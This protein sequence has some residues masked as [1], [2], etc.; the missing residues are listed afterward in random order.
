MASASTT[1]PD[2]YSAAIQAHDVLQ[3][4]RCDTLDI[5]F[6]QVRNNCMLL[7]SQ[8][9]NSHSR[10]DQDCANTI[11][12]QHSSFFPIAKQLHATVASCAPTTSQ[13]NI[14]IAEL[15]GGTLS[16]TPTNIQS[17]NA[18]CEGVDRF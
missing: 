8:M 13:L 1:C 7:F 17:C 3:R 12:F 6:S 18:E 4:P 9:I 15:R 16:T 14:D 11:Y 10:R 2:N 5:Q